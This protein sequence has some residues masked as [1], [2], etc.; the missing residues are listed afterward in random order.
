M[1]M[2]WDAECLHA[3]TENVVTYGGATIAIR[4]KAC[5]QILAHIGHCDGC[6]EDDCRLTDHLVA[7]RL[8]FC[9][10][11]CRVRFQGRERAAKVAANTAPKTPE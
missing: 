4:C 9:S 6:G 10:P 3:K 5:T 11:A 8:R 2:S 7:R 1:T